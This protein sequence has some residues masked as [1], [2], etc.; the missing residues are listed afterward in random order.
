VNQGSAKMLVMMVVAAVVAAT[1]GA[2]LL[3]D[4]QES[5]VLK[6]F[7]AGSLAEP[8][9]SMPDGTDLESLFEASHP[10]V[11][12]QVVSGGSVD[13]IKRVSG[14]NQTCDVIAVAD[15]SLIPSMMINATPRTADFCIEFARNSMAIAYTND[16][17]HADEIDQNNWYQVLRMPDVKF[18][19]SN[20]N[21]DP[22]GYRAQ[23][24]LLLAEQYYG[25]PW[26]YDDLV[27]NNT[28]FLGVVRD[29]INGTYTVEVPSNVEVTNTDKLMIRSAEVDLTSALESGAI[30]YLFIYQ[31]VA[32]RHAGSG[33]RYLELPRQVN[34]NDTAYASSYSKMRV[35]QFADSPDPEKTKV[36]KGV[37][38]VYGV[39]IPRNS[40]NPGLAEEFIAMLLGEQGREVMRNAG[41]EPIA[42]A[43]AG[44]WKNAVPESLR[45]LVG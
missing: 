10:G 43:H 21:D 41:Q 9:A 3:L 1:A 22:A 45:D 33:E 17:A 42:P 11:D 38:I 5:M 2:L 20:P 15:Y 37:P 25:D 26:I 44:Y 14:L 31:S 6:V 35:K 36:V 40:Q 16:S 32:E 19:M 39:T 4:R 13:M 34:L 12:V 29:S 24:L 23:M 28:N 30:D 27:L 7:I 8:F 18:G